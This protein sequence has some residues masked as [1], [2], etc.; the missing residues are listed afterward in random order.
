[1][2]VR[3]PVEQLLDF[4]RAELGTA[5]KVY[6]DGDPEAIPEFNLPAISVVKYSDQ[7]DDGPTGFRRVDEML[8]IKVIYNRADDYSAMDDHTELTEKKIRDVVEAIDPETGTYRQGTLKHALMNKF[9]MEGM[10]LSDSML[11]E[12]GSVARPGDMTTMEGHLTVT[13]SYLMRNTNV[14]T[15]QN[16]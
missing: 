13:L 2:I 7:N 1:M 11:F 15:G 6:Y 3:Q 12:L 4:L 16:A 14:L 5:F 9:T 8:Q 10:T